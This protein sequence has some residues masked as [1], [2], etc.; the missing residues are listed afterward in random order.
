MGGFMDYNKVTKLEI[1]DELQSV[2]DKRGFYLRHAYNYPKDGVHW[3]IQPNKQHIP[4]MI[5]R[6]LDTVWYG[7]EYNEQN[8]PDKW[9]VLPVDSHPEYTSLKVYCENFENLEDAIQHVFKSSY[10]I[11]LDKIEYNMSALD[12]IDDWMDEYGIKKR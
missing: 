2:V 1:T 10:Q 3:V 7:L 12:R 8:E 9:F 6:N 11:Y 4:F 5:T